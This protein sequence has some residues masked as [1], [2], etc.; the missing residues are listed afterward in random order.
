MNPHSETLDQQR[1]GELLEKLPEGLRAEVVS[2][3]T[4]GTVDATVLDLSFHLSAEE[5]EELMRL[6]LKIAQDSADGC[7]GP[8][9]SELLHV[10]AEPN[11]MRR[12]LCHAS[13]TRIATLAG[14][15]E[16]SE[17]FFVIRH[18][19]GQAAVCHWGDGAL[20]A[21]TMAKFCDS[22][23]EV[24]WRLPQPDGTFKEVPAAKFWLA[25]PGGHQSDHVRPIIRRY[26]RAEFMPGRRGPEDV[27]NLWR[28]WPDGCA[29][30]LREGDHERWKL[31]RQHITDNMCDGDD[32]LA[33]WF[34]GFLRDMIVEPSR[35]RP[36][37]VL[38]NGPQGSGKSLFCQMVGEWFGHHYCYAEDADRLF[39]K[40]NRH[41]DAML[42]VFVDEPRGADMQRHASKLKSLVAAETINIERKGF[43]VETRPKC[44]RVFAASNDEHI[45]KID[46]DD[47]RYLVLRVDAGE[48][49]NDRT[50]FAAMLKEWNSGG[51]EAMFRDLRDS[52]DWDDWDWNKRPETKGLANQKELSLDAARRAVQQMLD[53]G[54]LPYLSKVLD[55]GKVFVAT[56]GLLDENR[57][58][59]NKFQLPVGKLLSKLSGGCGG[60][61]SLKDARGVTKQR[62]GYELPPLG[63]ARQRWEGML[64]REIAWS[65]DDDAWPKSQ[66]DSPF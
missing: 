4:G 30:P 23:R 44:F 14:P 38:M 57:L 63:L 16:F 10:A 32:T 5:V 36:V 31:M 19:G 1:L 40:F 42:M 9:C 66:P 7:P 25:Q 55:N 43:D 59:P 37:A 21:Q 52:S 20:Q 45:A 64:K 56:E 58:D 6:G 34:L 48:H 49:N 18:L 15:E 12:L 50:Y 51:R 27:C 46:E 2:V 13:W 60:R 41:L 62:R 26:D 11:L 53:D 33:W 29:T 39:G 24:R 47:R 54:T 65:N 61:A 22:Y 3:S 35:N 17:R 28:G 8:I